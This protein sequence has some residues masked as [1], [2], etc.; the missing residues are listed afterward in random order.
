MAETY[1][2]IAQSAPSAT[3]LTDLYTVPANT[4]SVV[5]RLVVCNR[6]AAGTFRIAV[7]PLGAAIVNAHYVYYD[8]PLGVG[9]S[10]EVLSG[11]TLQATDKVR[12]YASHVDMGF[13]MFGSL[14]T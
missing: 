5:S 3:T 11:M 8:C 10:K 1:K 9:E 2:P 7:S 14:I 4:S 6:G 12:V 13:S